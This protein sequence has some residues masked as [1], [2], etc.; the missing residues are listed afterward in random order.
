MLSH[1]VTWWRH[2]VFQDSITSPATLRRMLANQ[3]HETCSMRWRHWQIVGVALS[4]F[5]FNYLTKIE[6]LLNFREPELIDI[7]PRWRDEFEGLWR[8]SGISSYPAK[9]LLC[10]FSGVKIVCYRFKATLSVRNVAYREIIKI[11][12]SYK[13]FDASLRRSPPSVCFKTSAVLSVAP[14]IT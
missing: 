10:P 4:C 8:N 6:R 2:T 11:I 3:Q 13:V 9:L 1:D 14:G 7:Q 5:L 12:S